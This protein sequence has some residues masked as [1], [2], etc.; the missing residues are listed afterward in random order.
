VKG[1]PAD[2]GGTCDPAISGGSSPGVL[3]VDYAEHVVIPEQDTLP[4]L[5]LR[6][7]VSAASIRKANRF[8]GD[9]L[10]LAPQKL[11]IPLS[12]SK[13]TPSGLCFQDTDSVQYKIRAFLASCPSL[14]RIEAK[15]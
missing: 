13:T 3:E 1:L 10:L 9:S 5:C 14:S 8:S 15:A 4:G 7:G 6:Y 12:L 2:I 11:I